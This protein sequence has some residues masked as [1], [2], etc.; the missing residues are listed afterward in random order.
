MSASSGST[1][2]TRLPSLGPRGEGWVAIQF[3]LIGATVGA[4]FLPPRW[5][6]A[7]AGPLSLAG[8]ALAVAG[9][10][11]S[12]AAARA[13][14]R[15]FTP[16]PRPGESAELVERGPYRLVRHPIYGAVLLFAAGFCLLTSVP[17]LACACALAVCW[18]LKARVEERFLAVRY[19]AYA[20]YLERTP[21]R[22]LPYVW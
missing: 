21:R 3:V 18:A 19:P 15:S 6:D 22:F 8:A 4:A 13:L 12:I 16:L 20:A 10:S 1:R 11:F 9:G 2:S 14:G 5:P 17:A 7:V